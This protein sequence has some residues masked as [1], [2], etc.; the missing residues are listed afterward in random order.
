MTTTPVAGLLVT[1]DGP[2]GAGKTTTAR[3]LVDRLTR[4]GHRVHPT[5]QPT[6]GELG[7]IARQRVDT[8]RGHAL[9]CLVA[10]DRYHHLATEIRPHKAARRIVV[11]DRYVAASLVLQR[12]DGVPLD[13]IEA[14]NA[15][16]DVP[17]LS[18]ILTVDPTVAAKRIDRRGTRHRFE[19]GAESAAR[20]SELYAEATRTLTALG[21]SL[22]VLDS[23]RLDPWEVAERIAT[24]IADLAAPPTTT[25]AT[26]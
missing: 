24:R 26:A 8:Y 20:E 13:F 18:V 2:G 9:A 4:H 19:T 16:A 7:Q 10:A 3:H 21:Y 14:V 11:C 15:P 1:L 25:A 22:L 6:G 12:M 5:T 23:T 17:D